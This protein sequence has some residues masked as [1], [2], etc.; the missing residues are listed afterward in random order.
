M[1]HILQNKYKWFR[2]IIDFDRKTYFTRAISCRNHPSYNY[3]FQIVYTDEDDLLDPHNDVFIYRFEIQE[4]F[5]MMQYII[6]M[7]YSIMHQFN[8][9]NQNIKRIIKKI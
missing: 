5:L 6:S 1:S 9:Y 7:Q 2:N 3:L 8:V 4:F